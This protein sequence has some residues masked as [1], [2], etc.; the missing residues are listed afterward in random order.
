MEERIV[1]DESY[2]GRLF[3]VAD[4]DARLRDADDLMKF[5]DAGRGQPKRIPRGSRVAVDAIREVP[6]GARQVALFAHALSPEGDR[7][8]GWTS[9]GNFAGLFLSETLGRIGVPAGSGQ[10]G[11][12]AVWVRGTYKGQVDLVRV[13][14]THRQIEV[15]SAQTRDAFLGLVGAARADGVAV[16]LNSGFRSWP[17]QKQ[18]YDGYMRGLAGYNL[19]SRPGN[20]NH[21]NGVAFDFD[22]GGGGS[23]PTYL[24]L[25]KHATKHGFVRTV[26][27]EVWHWEYLPDKAAQARSRAASTTW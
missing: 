9:V 11:P 13:V 14:G 19:A 7:A 8:H 24:W 2:R 20:S 27:S 26:K 17:E 18:L 1:S 15:V 10:Y 4:P 23:N 5:L 16:G 3:T 12:H 6:A 25:Q 22:V 21:Q